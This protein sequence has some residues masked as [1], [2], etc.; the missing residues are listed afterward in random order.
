MLCSSATLPVTIRSVTENNKVDRRVAQFCLPIGATC[1]MDG[2]A[3]YLAVVVIF[4]A[5]LEKMSLS[6]GEM[7]LTA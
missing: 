4:M 5:N 1:N 2:S 6:F 3:L 7:I